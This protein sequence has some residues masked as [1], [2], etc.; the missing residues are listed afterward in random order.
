[1]A[2]KSKTEEKLNYKAEVKEL[3]ELGPERLYFLWGP[4]DYLREQYVSEIKKI[5]IPEGDESFSY[6]LIDGADLQF[7]DFSLDIG[8]FHVGI[9]LICLYIE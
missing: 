9:V 6:R 2:K 7:N 8:I 4:E 1:M 5:C 3:R